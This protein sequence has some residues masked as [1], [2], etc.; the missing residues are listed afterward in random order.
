M[1]LS[2]V[3]TVFSISHECWQNQSPHSPAKFF[4]ACERRNSFCRSLSSV[5]FA[6]QSAAEKLCDKLRRL[7]KWL[8]R[9][10]CNGVQHVWTCARGLWRIASA[11][12]VTL[13][14]V[15]FLSRIILFCDLLITMPYLTSSLGQMDFC[16][17]YN[18]HSWRASQVHPGDPALREM[19]RGGA[20]KIQRETIVA[21]RSHHTINQTFCFLSWS[22]QY[23]DAGGIS[24]MN[25][26]EE[27]SQ[28]WGGKWTGLRYL[29]IFNLYSI[30]NMLRKNLCDS[31]QTKGEQPNWQ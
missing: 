9:D 4:N 7:G 14:R 12:L 21:P 18:D 10:A 17:I 31:P 16:T 29:G 6:D 25:T 15:K 23:S 1:F 20:A 8:F 13:L 22:D 28:K 27:E 30:Q 26:L 3:E 11:P 2:L 19:A 5:D 24:T